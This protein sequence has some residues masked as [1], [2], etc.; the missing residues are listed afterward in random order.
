MLIK[1]S[2]I[3]D[4]LK[5]A[6][7]LDESLNSIPL[8][9]VVENA[10]LGVNLVRLEDL[11]EDVTLEDIADYNRISVDSLAVVVDEGTAI[12]YPDI[13][14]ELPCVIEPVSEDCYESKLVD[15]I[16][17]LC[18]EN[19]DDDYI[20]LLEFTTSTFVG[21]DLGKDNRMTPEQK[22]KLNSKFASFGASVL[23]RMQMDMENV[24]NSPYK[25]TKRYY[26][27]I[28]KNL[29]RRYDNLPTNKEVDDG[30]FN[31]RMKKE[32]GDNQY[33][34]YNRNISRLNDL[35]KEA[36]HMPASKIGK[37][38]AKLRNAYHG[39]LLKANRAMDMKQAGFFRKI[40]AKIL[41]WIDKLADK[42]QR[43]AG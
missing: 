3:F 38:I 13:L 25:N 40:A 37:L 22:A 15:Y 1:E 24:K 9:P 36:V 34:A 6:I 29:Y 10:R 31:E 42:L 21:A 30:T 20:D 14:K 17:N 2:Q 16:C 11:N 8:I 28:S 35:Y 12:L 26:K 43:A 5:D 23:P 27:Y 39:Y 41:T 4:P 19:Y 7:I 18:E 32:T 33:K